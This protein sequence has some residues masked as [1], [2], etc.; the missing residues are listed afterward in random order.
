MEYTK[1][2]HQLIV[3]IWINGI[4]PEEFNLGIICPLHKKGYIMTCSNYRG[5][6]F[7]C[8]TYKVFSNILFKRLAPY[9][10]VIGDYQCG[11]PSRNIYK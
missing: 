2:L 3:K 10:D 4:I 6:S 9:V 11:I 8:T 7:L 5:I 1:Y